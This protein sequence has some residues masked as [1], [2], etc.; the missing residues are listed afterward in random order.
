[1]ATTI[2]VQAFNKA[3]S[4]VRTLDSIAKCRGSN[5]YNLVILQDG[6]VGSQQIEKYREP[7]AKTTAAI[8]SWIS[9]N[10]QC[11]PSVCFDRSD[12]NHGPYRTAEGLMDWAF[13]TSESVIFSEDDI[14]FERDALEWFERALAHPTFL[15]PQVWAI[16]GE[17]RFFDSS[18]EVPSLSDINHALEV[19]RT[20]K[21]MD[22][23][24]YQDFVPSSCFATIRDK[25]AEFGKTRGSAN[26]DRALAQRCRFEN[27]LCLWPVLA[28]CRDIGMHDPQGWSVSW[29][30]ADH[31]VVKNSYIV[32]GMLE[33]ASPNLTELVHGKAALFGEFTWAWSGRTA[34]SWA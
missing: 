6:Y 2:A 15:R 19:A 4:V 22:R 25:W 28:R 31:P 29:K 3:E 30:G 32:S 34:P 16:A 7:H 14:I 24:V 23:F 17:S 11:F 9:T 12:R 26:G 33:D 18:R 27:K 20:Q 13:E 8:E 21:L 1:M 5:E 10:G